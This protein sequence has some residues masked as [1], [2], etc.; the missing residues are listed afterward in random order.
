[1]PCYHPWKPYASLGLPP[2]MRLP[3]RQCIGCRLRESANW[4]T[5]AIHETKSHRYN[6]WLTLTYSDEHLPKRYN[7]GYTNPKTGQPIYSGSLLKQHVQDFIRSTRKHL[8][9]RKTINDYRIL[10]DY[11]THLC[12]GT[13]KQEPTKG[14]PSDHRGTQ[15]EKRDIYPLKLIPNLRYYYSGEYGEKYGRPHYHL[16][17]FGIEFNDRTITETTEQGFQ[18]YESR[19]LNELW[20]YGQAIIG[21]LNWETAAYTARYITK[22]ITGEKQKKHYEKIDSDT[23]EIINLLPEFADM[24]RRP[25]IANEWW[26]KYHADV[27]KEKTSAVRVRGKQIPPPRYYDKLHKRSFPDR[28]AVIKLARKIEAMENW[29]NTTP[30][31]LTAGEVITKARLSTA[32]HKL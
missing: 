25:G 21:D 1:M 19:R 20:P 26:N 23:G 2:T 4:A 18:L 27:Y 31:R 14:R 28:H 6:T 22:K 10:F 9:A 16:C 32:R 29:Q 17:L 5:R 8:S 13:S 11:K 15:L 24:S 3:C 7:T 12:D 30:K